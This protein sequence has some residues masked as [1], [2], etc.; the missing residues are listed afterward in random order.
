M[1]FSARHA[2]SFAAFA[3]II[4][5]VGIGVFVVRSMIETRE[6]AR[7]AAHSSDV[8]RA[9]GDARFWIV[10]AQVAAEDHLKMGTPETR[11]A[12]DATVDSI[13]ESLDHLREIGDADD[14][15]L[16]DNLLQNDM[17]ALES[18][19]RIFLAMER[20]EPITEAVPDADTANR[21]LALLETPAAKRQGSSAAALEGLVNEQGEH[22]RITILV[23]AAGL[24]LVL[25]LIVAVHTFGRREAR[26][27]VELTRLRTA[28]LTDSLTGLGNHRAF[29]E[30]LRR[31]VA[32]STRHK[33]A[34]V[35][36]IIDI[37]GFKEV[38]DTWGHGRGDAV[39]LQIAGI[40]N[41]FCRGED[42]AFRVGGD[43]FA[44]IL[45]H[46]E[47]ATAQHAM[48][49]L[50]MTVERAMED[51]PTVSIGMASASA[52][53]GDESVLRQQADS[54]LYEAKLKGRNASVL[55]V[56]AEGARPVFPA[57]KISSLR[58]LLNDGTVMAAFQPIWNL[59]D[60]TLLA[61]EALARIPA[62][63]EIAG[64]Q[65]AFDI[66]ERIGKCAELD[67]AC[68][69]A[70]LA[71]AADIPS[72]SLLFVNVSPYTLTH[73]EFSPEALVEE[74][75]AA[76]FDPASVVLEITERS[77]V[78]VS[79]IESAVSRLH[80]AGF[81]IALDDVG[82]GNAG[83]E[84]LRRV[85]VEFVKIDREVILSA[86]DDTMGRAAVMAIVAFASQAG[87]LVVAEGVETES[88]MELV[89]WVANGGDESVE[90]MIFAVQGYLLGYPSTE[91]TQTRGNRTGDLAA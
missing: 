54:A 8:S 47:G 74:F 21:I 39:L 23:C 3:L 35:L 49:Q 62:E 30:E 90:S 53:D 22:V 44:M 13:L 69:A 37:D 10:S 11:A 34:L 18:V 24:I 29:L 27:H 41:E 25:G 63:Y 71:R 86:I 78:S 65:L 5:F 40:L 67:R 77:T 46:T 52:C 43:E 16:V 48:E 76:G 61:H 1:G 6:A 7:D 60:D 58:R 72:G 70:V 31:Q 45:P 36:A 68:R 75:R 20:G 51:G 85:P 12:F 50:R 9:Y 87:A 2:S 56:A 80:E 84:M 14:V 91:F 19:K 81:K 66:A 73:A 89:R 64:P 33:E 32:R 17:A 55:F 83:L 4:V 59:G 15:A 57:A 38:N 82:A 28:A 42:Y 88:M 26:H 79:N